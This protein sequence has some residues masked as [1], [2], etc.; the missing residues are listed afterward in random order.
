MDGTAAG[1]AR[2]QRTMGAKRQEEL[3]AENALLRTSLEAALGEARLWQRRAAAAMGGGD[4]P[5]RVPEKPGGW[6]VV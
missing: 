5:K 2:L 3:E 6:D 4:R 1:G